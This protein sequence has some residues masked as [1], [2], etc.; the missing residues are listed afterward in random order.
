MI[1]KILRHK[2][3]KNI[4]F[5]TILNLLNSAI[6]F[7][8]LPVLTHHLSKEEFGI[9]DIFN[10]SSSILAPIIG[11][12]IGAS[13]IRFY[14]DKKI[15]FPR[16]VYNAILFLCF[17]GIILIIISWIIFHNYSIFPNNKSASNQIIV[18]A[19][20]YSLFSQ[21]CEVLL[22][23]W[24]AKQQPLHFGSF[25]ISKTL[26]D[27]GVSVYL[28][29]LM[30]MGW[31]GRV[32]TATIVAFLFAVISIYILYR[33]KLLEFKFE[34]SDIKFGVAYSAPIVVHSISGYIISFSDRFIIMKFAGLEEVGLY[35]VAYQIGMVMSFVS[36]SFNQAWTP[37]LFSKLEERN[38][39]VLAKIH[40]INFL[41]FIG[42]II[43]AIIIYLFVPLIYK[44]FIGENF[45]VSS[46]VA[47]WVLLGYSVNGM[48][49]MVVNYL[50]YFNK[51]Q[52]LALITFLSA[53]LNITLSWF[54]VQWYGIIGA[55][56]STFF[57]F[58]FMFILVYIIYLREYRKMQNS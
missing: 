27:L 31:E 2:V 49:K 57:S 16:F 29:A 55:A 24:R 26:V 9:I 30:N 3:S 12:N 53:V 58:L 15:N 13:I 22:A 8:L 33:I 23:V 39:L 47:L 40:K 36:N 7:L 34:L 42:M 19:I 10:T 37:F 41:Y 46:N 6:P 44:L 21:I 5:Y 51:T 54:F 4:G 28:I 17:S 32:Y 18:L 14:Y 52:V 38:K 56:I 48:Y 43:L 1:K 20:V 35:A 50:F 45:A 11:L 25:R